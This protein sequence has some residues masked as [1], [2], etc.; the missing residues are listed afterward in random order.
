M[1]LCHKVALCDFPGFA[2]ALSVCTTR[3]A[4]RFQRTCNYARTSYA[5]AIYSCDGPNGKR[6][7]YSHTSCVLSI[8]DGG[9]GSKIDMLLDFASNK[10]K[11]Q[12]LDATVSYLISSFRL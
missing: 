6:G 8:D 1:I 12:V 4:E 7:D 10:V 2:S 5:L 3:S 9:S 11:E